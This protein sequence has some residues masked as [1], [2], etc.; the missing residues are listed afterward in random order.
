MGA[1][2]PVDCASL[3]PTLSKLT[4]DL[5]HLY[6]GRHRDRQRPNFLLLPF[7]HLLLLEFETLAPGAGGI[8]DRKFMSGSSEDASLAREMTV[9][10]EPFGRKD[11][12]YHWFD[13]VEF[14]VS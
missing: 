2:V 6:K 13:N 7:H 5:P 4:R 14:L 1:P 3:Q 12:T 10:T 9:I 11:E 8:H